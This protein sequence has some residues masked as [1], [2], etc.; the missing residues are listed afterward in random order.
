MAELNFREA[1]NADP[2]FLEALMNLI[3]V[4]AEQGGVAK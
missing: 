2:D 4:L 1:V 3:A